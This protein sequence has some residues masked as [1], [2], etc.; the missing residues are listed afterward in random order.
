MRAVSPRIVGWNGK[1]VSAVTRRVGARVPRAGSL[2]CRPEVDRQT[3]GEYTFRLFCK[4]VACL[5]IVFGFF[6]L[7][8]ILGLARVV[9]AFCLRPSGPTFPV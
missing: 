2:T 6:V 7:V 1:R 5:E 9:G 8:Q 3:R 4:R